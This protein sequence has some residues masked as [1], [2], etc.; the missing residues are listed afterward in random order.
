MGSAARWA[1]GAPARQLLC[2]I[3]ADFPK[4]KEQSSAPR[5]PRKDPGPQ[6]TISPQQSPK[7]KTRAF[8]G[9]GTQ[10]WLAACLVLGLWVANESLLGFSY[11]IK[12]LVKTPFNRP[13][14]RTLIPF[15]SFF[16]TDRS[17]RDAAFVQR[18][19]ER[20][21]MRAHLREK[22]QLPKS[23]TDKKQMEAAGG[24]VTFPQDLLA[25]VKSKATSDAGSLFPGFGDLDFSSFRMTAQ[26]AMRSWQHPVQCPVM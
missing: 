22:Y 2:C 26:N 6:W 21:A 3:S 4:D 15:C 24:Q 20:A 12:F 16:P 13:P 9:S 19:A 10:F 17:K 18:K 23:R 25:I 8:F 5:C 7:V 11:K 14:P 1:C